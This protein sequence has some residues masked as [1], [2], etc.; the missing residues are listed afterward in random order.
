MRAELERKAIWRH[1]VWQARNAVE[2]RR[3]P[4]K[5]S[6]LV[7]GSLS[8]GAWMV[9]GGALHALYRAFG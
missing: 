8:V 7:L 2:P 1:S 4:A 5:L 9:L 6:L 3:W